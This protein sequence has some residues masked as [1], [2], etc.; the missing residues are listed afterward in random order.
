MAQTGTYLNKRDMKRG[1]RD[2]WQL[3]GILLM[4]SAPVLRCL[5]A[6]KLISVCWLDESKK[7]QGTRDGWQL[8]GICYCYRNVEPGTHGDEGQVTK[9]GAK[10]RIHTC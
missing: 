4:G 8:N 9:D 7:G 1:T 3:N 5:I 10:E 6:V 2:G